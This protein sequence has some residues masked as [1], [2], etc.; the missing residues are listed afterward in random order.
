MENYT[1][2]AERLWTWTKSS[3]LG[4]FGAG[5]GV[6]GSGD[7]R[8]GATSTDGWSERQ[9]EEERLAR[10]LT[11]S[12]GEFF[13]RFEGLVRSKMLNGVELLQIL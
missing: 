13:V 1:N 8:L 5:A 4:T 10:Q 12:P 3:V 2:G 9:A 11:D 7:G 6:K